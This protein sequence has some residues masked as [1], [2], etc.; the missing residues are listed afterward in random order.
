MTRAAT[1]SL[2]TPELLERI[3]LALPMRDLLLLQRTC[4]LWRD[5]ATTS[6]RIQRALFFAPL[7]GGAV[8]AFEIPNSPK[9]TPSSASAANDED[10]EEDDSL[11]LELRFSDGRSFSRNAS[12]LKINPLLQQLYPGWDNR[13]YIEEVI[14]NAPRRV[15]PPAGEYP[16]RDKDGEHDESEEPAEAE[17]DA[18]DFSVT[19]STP[20]HE[21][22]WDSWSTLLAEKA[23]SNTIGLVK[24]SHYDFPAF[25]YRQASWRRMLLCQPPL[26]KL[27]IVDL[28][29]ESSAHYEQDTGLT[30]EDIAGRDLTRRNSGWDDPK[31]WVSFR[32]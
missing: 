27:E 2:T 14:R 1:T 29:R 26:A 11:R 15:H 21:S 28:H 16:R 10:E 32:A 3:L 5:L 6:I 22:D 12:A 23:P 8:S 30:M 24:F 19:S 9:H 25:N 7:A 20:S 13:P 17:A 4:R 18:D 31:W